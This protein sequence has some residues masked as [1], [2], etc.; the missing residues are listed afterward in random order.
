MS[1]A[2]SFEKRED[3]IGILTFDLPNEKVNIF[4]TKTMQ[5]LSD[6]LEQL[7]QMTDIKCLLFMS[8]KPGIF[9][10][11]ADIKEIEQITDENIGYEVARKGQTVFAKF[12]NLPFPTIAVIDGACMG[13]GM[14]L[15]LNCT[16]RIATDSKKTKI[17][18][19]EVNLGLLPGWSGTTR[20]PRM[21]GL[22]RALDIILTGRHM[23]AKRAY[24]SGVIDKIIA[25]EWAHDKAIEFAKEVIA[26]NTKKL[27][28]RR[29][30]R[31]LIN[32]I[33]EKTPLGRKIV[34]SKAEK[35]VM[36][37]TG[38]H[39]PAPLMILETIKNTRKKSIN[40]ALEIE[41]RALGKLIASGVSKNLVKIFFW[42]EE[43]KKENGTDNRQIKEL[44]VNKAAVLGAGVMGGGIAQLFASR[45]IPIRVKDINHE[46]VAKAYQ[47]AAHI[48]QGKLERRRIKKLEMM[49]IMNR[50]SGTVDYSGFKHCDFVIEAVIE[51]IEIKKNVLS[52][53]EQHINDQTI[54]ATNTSSLNVDDM[55]EA[56]KI[57]DRFVGLHFFNPVHRMP[58]VEVVRGK[59][60]SDKAIA[61]VF[62]LSKK[63]GKTPIV[64][65]DSPGFL[66]N[67]LLLHYMVEAVSLLESGQSMQTIDS[68]M[69]KFGMPMGPI[70]LLD[71]VGIDVAVKVAKILQKTMADRMAESDLL[72]KML[73]DG[74]LGKKT[75]KGFYIY[76]TGKKANDPRVVKLIAV[77]DKTYLS[78][79]QLIQRMTYPMINE[80]ARCLDEGIAQ[81]ARDVDIGMIFGTGFAPF[82]GG[83]LRY[84]ESEGLEM[85]VKKLSAFKEE[86]GNRF[87]PSTSL[88]KFEEVGRFYSN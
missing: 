70:E 7:K 37:K 17:G 88:L 62:N 87:Q 85:V 19:P 46:A 13:G 65:N 15:A 53:L 35:M 57:K 22:Q 81:S 43:I 20:L 16:Y 12:G 47:Q 21:V 24:R 78:D 29:K 67:R 5:E 75:K 80:A 33:I 76:T 86:F 64:V 52:E 68:V 4:N 14:E 61:T 40:N 77:K 10:A 69:R 59:H 41:A 23:D 8:K 42:T 71:E 27:I 11:G 3:S 83:L 74:R 48:L 49:H 66:V 82:R 56:L 31:G 50:I 1:K 28:K 2:F 45:E 55:A 30:P 34:F 25:A 84:A 72:L 32:F 63:L 54:I 36:Q 18:L 38:G 9:I 60:S 51:D 58:L 44:P 79:D 73:E 39:Y 26:G 6:Q